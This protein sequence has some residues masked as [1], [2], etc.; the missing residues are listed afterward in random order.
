MRPDS[1]VIS[2]A[3]YYFR[4]GLSHEKCEGEEEEEEDGGNDK[5]HIW[6]RFQVECGDRWNIAQNFHS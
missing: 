4:P 5:S 3:N 1:R 2:V 6:F